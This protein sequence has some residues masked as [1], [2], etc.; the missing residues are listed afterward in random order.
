MGT[1]IASMASLVTYKHFTKMYP[2]QK[3]KYLKEYTSFCAL[4]VLV[5]FGLSCILE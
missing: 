4:F 2:N 5:L 1:L 3:G